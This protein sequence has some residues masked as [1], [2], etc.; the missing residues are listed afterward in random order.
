MVLY[1]ILMQRHWGNDITTWVPLSFSVI[2]RWKMGICRTKRRSLSKN[3][4]EVNQAH[5]SRDVKGREALQ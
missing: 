4:V 1:C 3:F 2:M 5:A